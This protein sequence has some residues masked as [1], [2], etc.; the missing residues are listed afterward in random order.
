MLIG[1]SRNPIRFPEYLKNK[2]NVVAAEDSHE[3]MLAIKII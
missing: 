2:Q 1:Y 3:D